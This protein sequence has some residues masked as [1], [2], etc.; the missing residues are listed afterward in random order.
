MSLGSVSTIIKKDLRLKCLRKTKAQSLTDGNKL[1]QF[2]RCHH[3]LRRYPASM[4]NFVWLIDDTLFTV[5]TA[6]NTQND[7]ICAP[8]GIL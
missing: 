8:V 6:R 4:V 1:A 5:E 7:G 3:P 2:N